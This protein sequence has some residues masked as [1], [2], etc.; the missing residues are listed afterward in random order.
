MS[1]YDKVLRCKFETPVTIQAIEEEGILFSDGTRLF[2]DHEQD[3]CEQVYADWKYLMPSDVEGLKEITGLEVF[4]VENA[5]IRLSFSHPNTLSHPIFVP[6]YNIQNG[7]YSSDLSLCFGSKES[8]A[9]VDVSES[10][11]YSE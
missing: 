2:T 11:F 3:C 4:V 6:C 7:Y 5:G 10:C 9:V 8:Y 1:Y